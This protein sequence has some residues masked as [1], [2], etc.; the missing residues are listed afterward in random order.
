MIFNNR[1]IVLSFVTLSIYSWCRADL[2]DSLDDPSLRRVDAMIAQD[3][4]TTHQK[5]HNSFSDAL[6][7]VS[8]AKKLDKADVR[9]LASIQQ[10]LNDLKSEVK[11]TA[12]RYNQIY[13]SRAQNIL[14][15]MRSARLTLLQELKHKFPHEYNNVSTESMTQLTEDNYNKNCHSNV[16]PM[17]LTYEELVSDVAQL[18]ARNIFLIDKKIDRLKK[19]YEYMDFCSSIGCIL[20]IR[21]SN[22]MRNVAG[23]WI[24]RTGGAW[25]HQVL[26]DKQCRSLEQQCDEA[27]LNLGGITAARGMVSKQARLFFACS[28][29]DRYDIHPPYGCNGDME[30]QYSRSE[31][32]PSPVQR[33]TTSMEYYF[34]KYREEHKDIAIDQARTETLTWTQQLVHEEVTRL[35]N[36]GN[37]SSQNAEKLCAHIEPIKKEL[38]AEIEKVAAKLK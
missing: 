38:I 2:P 24:V 8:D 10:N 28:L 7:L 33:I 20:G 12:Q 22:N 34:K 1:Y 25:M 26:V 11:N 6:K 32:S 37:Q 27:S 5:I 31:Y 30:Q 23:Y 14:E 18:E 21:R 9:G 29:Y 4:S 17:D 3:L 13:L 19:R 36:L 16:Q 15:A 35:K